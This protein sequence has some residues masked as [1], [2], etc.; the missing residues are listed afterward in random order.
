VKEI[1]GHGL[2]K[3]GDAIVKRLIELEQEQVDTLLRA[4]RG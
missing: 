1:S 3:Q 4:Q 2:P